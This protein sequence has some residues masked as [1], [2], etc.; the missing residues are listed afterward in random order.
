MNISIALPAM[1]PQPTGHPASLPPEPEKAS[2]G[3]QVTPPSESET[4]REFQSGQR[5]TKDEANTAP[6]SVMQIKIMEILEQQAT[7][8]E[9]Q[10]DG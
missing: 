6:P 10:E 4:S 7:E 1:A 2:T 9:S 3:Q 5:D 8:L